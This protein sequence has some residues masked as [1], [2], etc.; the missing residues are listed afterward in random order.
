MNNQDQIYAFESNDN[1]KF[2]TFATDPNLS[3]QI[4]LIQEPSMQNFPYVNQGLF[5][6]NELESMRQY[7]ERNE[8]KKIEDDHQKIMEKYIDQIPRHEYTNSMSNIK[9]DG[10]STENM[11]LIIIILL[12]GLIGWK[13]VNS[14]K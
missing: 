14:N 5:I 10:L 4:P 8:K 1:S 9:K 12:T 6:D 7:I 3:N 13:Y 11:M 2:S